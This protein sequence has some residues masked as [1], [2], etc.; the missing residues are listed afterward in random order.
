MASSIWSRRETSSDISRCR[1]QGSRIGRVYSAVVGT[2]V[3]QMLLRLAAR[4]GLVSAHRYQALRDEVKELQ[5]EAKTAQ[6]K[7]AEQ[8]RHAE[9][10]EAELKRHIE[11]LKHANK[12]IERLRP[13]EQ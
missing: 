10:A 12:E 5:R 13:H 6:K 9:R 2:T 3:K 8:T 11:L 1:D 7:A 4:F